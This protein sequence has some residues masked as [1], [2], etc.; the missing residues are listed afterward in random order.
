M[1]LGSDGGDGSDSEEYS[2]RDEKERECRFRE[3]GH[4]VLQFC[5]GELRGARLRKSSAQK[6]TVS[7]QFRNFKSEPD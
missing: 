5:I 2:D 1:V 6:H 4:D 3:F 7:K